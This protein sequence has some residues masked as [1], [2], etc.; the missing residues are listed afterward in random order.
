[1]RSDDELERSEGTKESISEG[2]GSELNETL[3]C[4]LGLRE[5][6]FGVDDFRGFGGLLLLD[7]QLPKLSRR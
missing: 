6:D 2:L 4:M 5:G 7:P 3:L 1:M